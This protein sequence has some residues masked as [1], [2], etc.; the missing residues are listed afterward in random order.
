[1]HLDKLT[2]STEFIQKSVN[3]FTQDKRDLLLFTTQAEMG[4]KFR[5][6]SDLKLS[7]LKTYKSYAGIDSFAVTEGRV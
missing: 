2:E 1:M 4:D 5:W 3:V 6:E 7:E